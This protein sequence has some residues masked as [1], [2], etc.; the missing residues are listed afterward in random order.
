VTK[1]SV[2][3]VVVLSLFTCGIYLLV[4][5]VK[6]KREMVR[7]GADIPT[8]WLLLVPIANIWQIWKW[9]GGVEHVTRGRLTQPV[10][11]LIRVF[12]HVIGVAIIQAELNK[13]IDRNVPAQLPVARVV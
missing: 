8:T 6:T 5:L 4:W 11:F 1:R 7:A 9:C 2:A 13:A 3:A 10:A 12:L